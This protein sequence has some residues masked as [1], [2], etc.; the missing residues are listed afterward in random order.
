MKRVF[1]VCRHPLLAGGVERLLLQ[2]GLEVVGR[3]TDVLA[4]RRAVE[5]VAP[6]VVILEGCEPQELWAGTALA[7]A[8]L[9]VRVIMLSLGDNDMAVVWGERR[10]VSEVGDL[11]TA[12]ASDAPQELRPGCGECEA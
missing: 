2:A 9:G 1:L 5:T 4:A 8:A 11:L 10:R 3:E 7:L 6:D 12:I